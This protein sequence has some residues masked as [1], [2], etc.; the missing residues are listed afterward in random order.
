MEG[1]LLECLDLVKGLTTFLS[2]VE[3]EKN[4][5]RILRVLNQVKGAGVPLLDFLTEVAE[6]LST[7]QMSQDLR[8]S[9]QQIA[10]DLRLPLSI[11]AAFVRTKFHRRI[12]ENLVTKWAEDGVSLTTEADGSQESLEEAV[13][14]L[15]GTVVDLQT[16][17]QTA[18]FSSTLSILSAVRSI[19]LQL[20]RFNRSSTM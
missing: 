8:H 12:G 9:G 19:G 18:H 14:L 4:E 17:M 11:V 6:D 7:F 16:T 13:E 20:D 15:Q 1:D 3:L 5:R 2:E 10:D